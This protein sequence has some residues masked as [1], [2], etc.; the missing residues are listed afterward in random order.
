MVIQV[1]GKVRD[2]LAVPTDISDDEAQQRALASAQVQRYLNG[3]PPKKLIVVPD[4]RRL[5]AVVVSVVV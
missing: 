1:N 2:R 4:R 5:G 3:N